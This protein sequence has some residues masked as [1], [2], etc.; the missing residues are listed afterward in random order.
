MVIAASASCEQH[1]IY[2]SYSLLI[3]LLIFWSSDPEIPILFGDLSFFA[4]SAIF[5][6]FETTVLFLRSRQDASPRDQDGA[7]FRRGL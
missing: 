2:N 3:S 7:G 1:L 5:D 6:F 4:D